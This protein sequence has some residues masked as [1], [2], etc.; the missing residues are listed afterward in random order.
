MIYIYISFLRYV[1]ICSGK[2]DQ[3]RGPNNNG[4]LVLNYV[5]SQKK[6]KRTN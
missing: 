4:V 6:K 1:R 5:L 3:C 2:K